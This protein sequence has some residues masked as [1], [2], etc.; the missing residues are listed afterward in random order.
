MIYV[1]FTTQRVI[2]LIERARLVVA[3]K[4]HGASLAI[5]AALVHLDDDRAIK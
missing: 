4:D 2:I 5:P 1:F 3:L